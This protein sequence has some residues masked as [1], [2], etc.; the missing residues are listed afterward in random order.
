MP[1]VTEDHRRDPDMTVPGDICYTFYR[2][3][4]R[5]WKNEPRWTTAHNIYKQMRTILI[6]AHHRGILPIQECDSCTAY[7]LAWQVFFQLYVMPYEIDKR[8]TNGDI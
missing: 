5:K 3:M 8:A 1:F 7:E 6:N 2:E 4:V